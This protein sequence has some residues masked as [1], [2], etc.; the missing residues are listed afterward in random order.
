MEH[1]IELRYR[2]KIAVATL[3]FGFAIGYLVSDTTFALLT[4]PLK[5]AFGEETGRRIIYTGL[6]E[7]FVTKMKLSLFCAFMF[8][9]PVFATQ[10][11]LFLAPGLYKHERGVLLPY[12]IAAPVLFFLGASMAYFYIF[13]AAWQFFLSFETGSMGE[14]S[15]LGLPLQLEARMSEYLD[16]AMSIILAFGLSFQLPIL[17]T[18]MV[19][20]GLITVETLKNSRRYA[21]VILITVAAILTPPDVI[22][23]LGLFSALYLLYE[24]SIIACRLVKK[25]HAEEGTHA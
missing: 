7:A 16:L 25:N 17:L 21:I 24:L 11:Y 4:L 2:L 18:L 3:V 5:H 20:I 8:M 10:I 19:R 22:S 9:F 15:G 13:P 14:A 6:A 12:L 1:L 23:Q